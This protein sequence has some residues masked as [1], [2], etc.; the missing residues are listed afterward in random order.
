MS[1]F[2]LHALQ[3]CFHEIKL[4]Y[5]IQAHI[6]VNKTILLILTRMSSNKILILL[7]G[8]LVLGQNVIL[9]WK[10]S[11]NPQELVFV[12]SN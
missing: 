9:Q 6:I 5:K 3:T 8:A 4:F 1:A 10:M 2:V 7:G 12:H 11:R